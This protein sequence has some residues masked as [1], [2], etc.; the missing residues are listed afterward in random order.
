MTTDALHT[1]RYVAQ[2]I[3]DGDGDYV[4]LVK[5]NQPEMLAD[6]QLLFQERQVV[7]ET[8]TA[9]ETVDPGHG[10]IE[11]RR[12]TA[13]TALVDYRD[14]RAAAGLRDRAHGDP[15]AQRTNTLRNCL[16]HHQPIAPAC[17]C[18]PFAQSGPSALGHRKPVTLGAG[19]HLRRRSSPGALWQHPADHG[20]V[21]QSGHRFMRTAGETNVAAAGRRFAAQ[22]WAALALIGIPSEN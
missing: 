17:R 12:L 9:I 5:G 16:W 20:G 1:Q 19:C 15:Q 2:T 7:A 13:S 10:R 21:A 14:C 3:L 18:Q 22:P 4:M 6:I 8:L 11:V